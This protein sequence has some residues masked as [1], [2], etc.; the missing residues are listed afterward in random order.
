MAGQIVHASGE[1][2][3]GSVPPG[4]HA[5]VLAVPDVKSLLQVRLDLEEAEIP[6]TLICE[7][8]PPWN[9][10]PTAI[11]LRPTSDRRA[12]RRVLGRLPL[13]K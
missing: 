9:G 2:V 10:S 13:L 1:S 4:T 3:V 11:G 5:V 7:P 6:H 12:V 8:D